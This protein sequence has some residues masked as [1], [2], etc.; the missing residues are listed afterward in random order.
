MA[1]PLV[2]LERDT[3]WRTQVGCSFALGLVLVL[4]AGAITVPVV[5]HWQGG[6]QEDWV[7]ALFAAVFGGVGLLMWLSTVHQ[8][9]A[10]RT[11]E[12]E[13]WI[14][15]VPLHA[16]ERVALRVRQPGPVALK[17]LRGRLLCEVQVWRPS[18]SQGRSGRGSWSSTFPYDERF[19]DLDGAVLGSGDAL[20][21]TVELAVPA[22]ARLSDESPQL[23]VRWRIEVW[24]RVRHWPDFMHPF[25][26]KVI[27]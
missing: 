19:F 6:R 11:P 5:T 10:M 26:L 17:S 3:P 21:R 24:G 14:E 22:D 8:R 15:R 18:A 2:R 13:V 25:P 23:R 1:E 7:P 20:D 12:T 4:F 27:G 9:L 16:G